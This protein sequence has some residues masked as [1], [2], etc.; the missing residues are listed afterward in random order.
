MICRSAA[1][2]DSGKAANST[3]VSNERATALRAA[4]TRDSITDGRDEAAV[5]V[6]HARANAPT[7]P[8][9]V[10]IC[11]VT[12]FPLFRMPRKYAAEPHA[13]TDQRCDWSAA[14]CPDL[15]GG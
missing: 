1:K 11:W 9:A 10:A 7:A 13:K 6:F 15:R 4:G 2:A 14:A 5:H 12:G 8:G 3:P